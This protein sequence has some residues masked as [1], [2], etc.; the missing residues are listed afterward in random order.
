MPTAAAP[1]SSQSMLRAQAGGG[2][3]TG[4]GKLL[5]LR[6]CLLLPSPHSL[7]FPAELVWPEAK[8]RPRSSWKEMDGTAPREGALGPREEEPSS[9]P[10]SS[11]TSSQHGKHL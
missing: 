5:R 11:P 4:W 8:Q 6:H 3:E 2:V 10:Y 1:L 7:H 9:P